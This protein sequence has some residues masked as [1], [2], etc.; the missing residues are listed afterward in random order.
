M[1]MVN[2]KAGTKGLVFVMA[3]LAATVNSYAEVQT[4]F[5]EPT[6][7]IKFLFGLG[8]GF[9]KSAYLG[10]RTLTEPSLALAIYSK[11][12]YV[13]FHEISYS[14]KPKTDISV[15]LFTHQDGLPN[16]EDIPEALD[17]KS[18]DSLDAGLS[19]EKSIK[20][21]RIGVVVALDVTDT[22]G[23]Y[24]TEFSAGFDNITNT[25]RASM[26]IGARYS[27]QKRND[28]YFGVKRGEENAELLAYRTQGEWS[29]FAE[30]I[31]LK[32]FSHNFALVLETSVSSLGGSAKDSPRT[33]NNTDTAEIEVFAGL[34]WQFTVLGG[35]KGK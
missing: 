17:I 29:F 19:L 31:Y 14:F 20:E 18:G 7:A 15:K 34:L 33:I 3:Y 28:Y 21:A 11:N 23:G 2:I 9:D 8:G 27:D 6:D 16:E 30:A 1:F 12:L 24:I 22:H 13:D 32:T 25:T 26:T 10:E 4:K 35:N 5:P